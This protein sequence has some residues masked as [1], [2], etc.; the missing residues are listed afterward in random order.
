MPRFLRLA[1][2]ACLFVLLA[3]ILFSPKLGHAQLLPADPPSSCAGCPTCSCVQQEVHLNSFISRTEADAGQ[4]YAGVQIHSGFGTTLSFTLSYNTYDADGSRNMFTKQPGAFDTVLGY[5]WTFTFND[6]LFTQHNGDM[7]R[8][9]PDGRITRFALQT[10]GTYITSP[11]YFETLVKNNDGSFDLTDKYQ[12]DYHYAEV[13]NTTFILG[14]GPVSRIMSTTDREGNVT[15][16]GYDSGGDMT[17]VADTYGRT[18]TFS[19]NSNHHLASASDPLGNTTTFAYDSTGR[20]LQTITD[21]NGKTTSYGYDTFH[22]T[23]TKTDRDGRL[24]T[25]TYQ[26][27]LP[28]SELDGAGNPFYSLT[29][30]L[31]WALNLFDMYSEYLRV[32]TP[33]TTSETDGWGNVWQYSYDSNAHPTTVVAPDGAT[34]TYTYDPGTLKVASVTDANNHTTSY[35]YDTR[36]NLLTRTDA[37]GQCDDL[38]I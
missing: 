13:P 28:Y 36:G 22:Q 7:F 19:Y 29:N 33:S 15:T 4:E 35:T 10:D 27:R 37:L 24:F 1:A 14:S 2:Y 25:Y 11:G 16:Y 18:I 3:V 20:Q 9:A 31:N 12:T 30:P 26:S 5:G 23:V 8:L 32:Y 38:Y 21:P 17:N 6:L 34:T